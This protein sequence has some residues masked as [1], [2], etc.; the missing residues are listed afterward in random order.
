MCRYAICVYY[1]L[2][3]DNITCHIVSIIGSTV[4]GSDEL[5]LVE[6]LMKIGRGV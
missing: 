2:D 3:L 1:T 5:L 4:Y 6:V